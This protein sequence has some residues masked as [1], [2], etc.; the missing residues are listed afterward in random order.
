MIKLDPIYE[1]LMNAFGI[2][3]Y[4]HNVFQIIL[5]EMRKYN[6]F[7]IEVDNIGSIFAV[8]PSKQKDAKTVMIAGHMDEVGL[9]ISDILPNGAIKVIPIGGLVAEVF[10]SQ[11]LYAETKKGLVPGI[12]GSV[13][14]H[15]SKNQA[16]DFPDLIFDIGAKSKEDVL[17]AGVAVGD[18]VLPKNDFELNFN[19]TKAMSKAVDNRWGCGMALEIIRDFNDVDLPFNLVVGATVQEEVGLRGAGTSVFKFKPD[20]FLA[21]DASPLND[22]AD[23]KASGKMG[24]GF[25]IRLFDPRNIMAPR[26]FNYFK[27]LAAQNQINYQVYI[28]KGGTD[29]ARALDSNDGIIATTIGLPARYIHSTV[30]M[31]DLSDHHAAWLMVRALLKDLTN[32]KI[33]K[34]QNPLL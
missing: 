6:Q 15:L 18:M 33:A 22:L 7:K 10:I 11:K 34:L 32:E 4:E 21:L 5:A 30:A 17:S 1:K 25:L 2:S 27:D 31:F 14:P 13:P 8:K 16:A 19:G 20:F 28:A 26:L 3:A 23:P 24:D 12:I 9:M 29:A